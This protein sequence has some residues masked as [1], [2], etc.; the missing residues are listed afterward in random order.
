MRGWL[1]NWLI[2][3]LLLW[4]Y[5]RLFWLWPREYVSD[6]Q[7]SDFPWL[8]TWPDRRA[9]GR[10]VSGPLPSQTISVLLLCHLLYPGRQLRVEGANAFC[11]CQRSY[12]IHLVCEN[13]LLDWKLRIGKKKL[14][15]MHFINPK[16]KFI[17]SSQ[18]TPTYGEIKVYSLLDPPR[19]SKW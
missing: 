15:K 19:N 16:G 9:V 12:W 2:D 7:T 6:V 8:Q 14:K 11:R 10:G 4:L 3:W 1:I 17:L 18:V 13:L 5:S